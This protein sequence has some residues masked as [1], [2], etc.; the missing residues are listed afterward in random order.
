M[1]KVLI[2]ED[3]VAFG[4]ELKRNMQNAGHDVEI[5]HTASDGIEMLRNSRYDVLV[6]DIIIQQDGQ[7]VP[8]GGIKLVAWARSHFDTHTLPIIAMTGTHK[9][10]GMEN[11]LTT[12]EQVGANTSLEKPF[13]L[14]D[15]LSIIDRLLVTK[16]TGRQNATPG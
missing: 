8:D 2:L 1:A 7:S 11:I 13:H 15:L 16:P 3:D 5:C 10:P 9:F 12:T 4:F 14:D 6:S